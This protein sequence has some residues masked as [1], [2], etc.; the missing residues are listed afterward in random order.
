MRIEAKH[1]ERAKRL[2]ERGLS[3][4]DIAF[5]IGCSK[6]TIQRILNPRQNELWSDRARKRRQG[7]RKIRGEDEPIVEIPDHVRERWLSRAREYASRKDTTAILM[8]DPLSDVCA[9]YNPER[10]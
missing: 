7:W 1:V 10:R 5:K 2:R 3:Y 6:P 9:L 4:S 8:N